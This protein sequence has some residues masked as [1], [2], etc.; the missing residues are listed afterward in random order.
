[1]PIFFCEL[2]S[3]SHRYS[4]TYV[5]HT[6]YARKHEN[7]SILSE[8]NFELTGSKP[9]V[10][11]AASCGLTWCHMSWELNWQGIGWE[12]ICVGMS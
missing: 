1:M 5:K 8:N 9:S 7:M 10:T 4:K 2:T 3:N 6:S 11:C 12:F